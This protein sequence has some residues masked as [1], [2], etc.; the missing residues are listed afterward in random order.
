[1]AAPYTTGSVTVT[2][3]STAVV[4]VGTGWA[5]ALIT[6]GILI[7]NGES[8]V[9]GQVNSDTT[10]TLVSPWRGATASAA[11]YE[12]ARENA[13]ASRNMWAV[14]RMSE[15]VARMAMTA[16]APDGAGALA[17]RP[18]TPVDGY[19]Y[20]VIEPGRP[21]Q[22][23]QYRSGAW[24]DAAAIGGLTATTY[25]GAGVPP[26][27]TGIDGS[28]YLDIAN[29][30]TYARV[31]GAWVLSGSIIG[32]PTTDAS[33]LASGTVA[34]A[35]LPAPLATLSA[36]VK[37]LLDDA[38]LAAFRAT[39]A[40]QTQAENDAR[41]TRIVDPVTMQAPVRLLPTATRDI[42]RS[43]IDSPAT[44]RTYTISTVAADVVTITTNGVD[45]FFHINMRDAVMVR[46]W[47]VSKTP[48][49]SAWVD[50]NLAAN[51]FRV[52][53]PAHVAGWLPGETLVVGDPNPTGT[54]VLQMVAL[55][56]SRHLLAAHGAV[57][58]Q[59][60][61]KLSFSP[62]GV[63]GKVNMDVSATGA[64]GSAFGVHSNSDGSRQSAFV[65]VFTTELSPISNSNL[66]FVRDVLSGGTA[67]AATRLLR[68]AG[69]F[70]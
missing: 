40:V 60:G 53:N 33:M 13:E 49:E 10:L 3:G 14:D 23:S 64:T 31:A 57:F 50:L 46:V 52:S 2:N 69:V 41:F 67:M 16:I 56:I 36:D 17:L 42:W 37:S 43:D 61:L 11:P 22:V 70:I 20:L 29:G 18:S 4:G 1:M 25:A 62:Q 8:A 65:D 66:L 15:S 26:V 7:V 54:N 32:P 38:D 47:N 44:P 63:G 19:V 58:R 27:G 28:T 68:L 51:Q 48:D 30:D 59:R 5:I 21:V 9:I 6:G 39:L 24:A 55:D 45:E 35:R 12:I 34:E